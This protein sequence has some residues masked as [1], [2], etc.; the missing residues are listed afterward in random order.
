MARCVIGTDLGITVQIKVE[1]GFKCKTS[2]RFGIDISLAAVQIVPVVIELPGVEPIF[3][4]V[5]PKDGVNA[6][7]RGSSKRLPTGVDA[8]MDLRALVGDGYWIRATH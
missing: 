3:G 6:I 8:L 1:V 4:Y 7:D 2:S 5:F